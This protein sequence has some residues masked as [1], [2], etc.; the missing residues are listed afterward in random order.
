MSTHYTCELAGCWSDLKTQVGSFCCLRHAW[1]NFVFGCATWTSGKTRINKWGGV[2]RGDGG[3]ARCLRHAKDQCG[4]AGAR[5]SR[6][7]DGGTGVIQ[8]CLLLAHPIPVWRTCGDPCGAALN[9]I[10]LQAR[11]PGEHGRACKKDRK[12]R[13]EKHANTANTRENHQFG[14]R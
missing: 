13:K 7:G 1:E 3:R 14:R 10:L 11:G 8:S 2:R 4:S 5:E 12:S 6:E 9:T